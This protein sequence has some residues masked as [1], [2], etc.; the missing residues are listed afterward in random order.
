MK[1][2][3]T[4]R[5]VRIPVK[6]RQFAWPKPGNHPLRVSTGDA[7]PSAPGLLSSSTFNSASV[8]IGGKAV[9]CRVS[10]LLVAST[11]H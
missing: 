1:V 10:E 3:N 8:M 5:A 4:A 2:A 7:G 6:P 11:G 9:G